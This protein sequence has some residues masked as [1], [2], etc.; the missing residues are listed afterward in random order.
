[1]NPAPN[2]FLV[3]PMGAGK[4]TLGKRL[5]EH[6]HL[7][8]LDLDDEIEQ[9]LA[10]LARDRKRPLLQA[11]DRRERLTTMAELR[12]PLYEATADLRLDAD[13]N[14]IQRVFECAIAQLATHWR[15]T[16]EAA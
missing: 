3:G 2:L 11:P 7:Q 8:F 9:Q 12:G 4:T 10:R 15:L 1:M 13:S 16:G 6:F 14:Q 5:A